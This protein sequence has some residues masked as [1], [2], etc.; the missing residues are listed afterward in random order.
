M[1]KPAR[2]IY[3]GVVITPLP[4]GKYR[5]W[6]KDQTLAECKKDIDKDFGARSPLGHVFSL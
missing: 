4:S 3:K 5:W 2:I 6:K 1:E